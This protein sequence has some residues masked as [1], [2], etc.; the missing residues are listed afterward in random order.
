MLS[1][2]FHLFQKKKF[3][4]LF[5]T[6]ICFY[7]VGFSQDLPSKQD[8]L[9][10]YKKIEIFS[11]KRHLTKLI[12]PLIFKPA[13]KS[14]IR[15]DKKKTFKK[16][17]RKKYQ[18][19]E[20]KIIRRITIE[21]YG[22]FEYLIKDTIA[23]WQGFLTKPGNSLHLKTRH[24]TIRNLL[25]IKQGA[26][27]DSLLVKE[28]E[29]L[30]R[31][32]TFISD[33][34]IN[35]SQI[36]NNVDSI[37]IT[38]RTF[39]NWS[40]IPGLSISSSRLSVDLD[41]KNFLGLGHGFKNGINWNHTNG[42]VAHITSYS[43][44]NINNTYINSSLFYEVDEFKNYNTGIF[45][46]RPF[47]SPLA[48]WA[49]G[50]SIYQNSKND[51]INYFENGFEPIGYK[52]SSQDLWAGKA[53]QVFKGN[54]ELDRTTNLIIAARYKRN[55]IY[56]KNNS[57]SDSLNV[58]S[59]E[60]LFLMDF[61][62]TN[63]NY[64]QDKYIYSYGVNEDVPIGKTYK[65]T[66]GHIY[67][68]NL[69]RQYIGFLYRASYYNRWG[70]LSYNIGYGTFLN[71]NKAEQGSIFAGLNYFTDLIEIGKWR[72][73]QF[74]KPQ[75]TIGINRAKY[76]RLILSNQYG[77]EGFSDKSISGNDRILFS[78]QTQTYAPWNF[79]GFRFGPFLNCT[80][81]MVGRANTGFN[82]ESLHSSIGF[83]VL[84]KN[85]NL[86]FNTFQISISFYS[87]VPSGVQDLYKINS[88]E[89]SDFG[90]GDFETGKPDVIMYQ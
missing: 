66:L 48:K 50:V 76:E 46:E 69:N 25:L 82:N 63:L 75:I 11:N 55:R 9:K 84:I 42:K 64:V 13:Q 31:G 44:P 3:V 83:G 51:S 6:Y 26:P 67:K 14:T 37:D 90:F 59:N 45:V 20:G 27:F 22:P 5:F 73:R 81:G 52:L 39:D 35:A 18:S 1:L 28:S 17:P 15:V 32:Q 43:I 2:L 56:N 57:V 30:V 29:R 41:E 70:Y 68:N 12:Y 88:F 53:I 71:G 40:L 87:S 62:I 79:L 4:L 24:F 16:K 10:L 77:I 8:S 60:D 89:T 38:V 7:T 65:L 23:M 34:A 19:F 21:T 85:E 78:F 74:V 58:I 36:S 47:Y 61:R 80:L 54:T 33:V 49:A 86:V 72:F